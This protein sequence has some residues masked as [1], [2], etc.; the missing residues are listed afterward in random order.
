MIKEI[1]VVEVNNIGVFPPVLNLIYNLL[2]NGYKVNFI[3]SGLIELPENVLASKG[4]NGIEIRNVNHTRS[5]FIVRRFLDRKKLEKRTKKFVVEQ[6]KHSDI[7]W[8]T[9]YNTV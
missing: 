4:F 8:T 5:R 1:T 2:N 6:M 3:G 9:S 7:M